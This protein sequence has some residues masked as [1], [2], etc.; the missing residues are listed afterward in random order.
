MRGVSESPIL[1]LT[2]W[3]QHGGMWRILSLDQTQ[4]VVELCS[5]SGEPMEEL[6]SED[7]DLLRYLTDRA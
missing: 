5:C 6:R 3:G 1:T 7:P 2:R 4:A